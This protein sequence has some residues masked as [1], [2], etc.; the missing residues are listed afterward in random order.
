MKTPIQTKGNEKIS[1]TCPNCG[2]KI[3]NWKN[4]FEGLETSYICPKCKYEGYAF[5]NNTITY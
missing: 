1:I 2:F 5:G 3:K 4:I